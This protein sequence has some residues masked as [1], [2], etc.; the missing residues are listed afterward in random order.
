MFQG[1]LGTRFTVEPFP[2]RMTP[3]DARPVMMPLPRVRTAS[4]SRPRRCCC[5]DAARSVTTPAGPDVREVLL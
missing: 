2:R 4:G 3:N 5:Q 1:S